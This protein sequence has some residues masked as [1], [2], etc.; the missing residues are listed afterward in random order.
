M[1]TMVATDEVPPTSPVPSRYRAVVATRRGGPEVL[2]VVERELRLPKPDEARIRVLAASVSA[3]DVQARYGHSP[4]RTKVPFVPGY[5]VI[6]DVDAIG[7]NETAQQVLHRAA[8]ARSG[9]TVLII[10]ASGGI[11]TA[12]TQLGQLAGPRMYG[13]DG[14]TW[15]GR[16][17][18]LA[19][20]P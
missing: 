20:T 14:S 17:S 19:W 5:S 6:G 13:P 12:L 8:R 18:P 7:S 10:G 3:P 9:D 4:F 16:P 15:S 11:G 1:A 2:E